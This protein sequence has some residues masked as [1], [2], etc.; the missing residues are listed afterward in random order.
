MFRVQKIL[1]A[2]YEEIYEPVLVENPFTQ[3]DDQDTAIFQY[4][5]GLTCNWLLLGSDVF[6]CHENDF[7]IDGY[8][9]P[10]IESF[11]LVSMLPVEFL[12]FH[13]YRKDNRYMMLLSVVHPTKGTL[14]ASQSPL[15]FEFGGHSYKQHFWHTWRELVIAIRVI[16]PRYRYVTD[17]T[18][19]AS[20]E[21]QLAEENTVAQNH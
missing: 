5:I 15:I 21:D 17:S 4:H 2:E 10:E 18:P 20:T 13:F 16:P 3:L 8:V 9:D 14:N 12:R 7:E 6:H 1:L 19:F 11:D